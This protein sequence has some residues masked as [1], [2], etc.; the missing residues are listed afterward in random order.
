MHARRPGGVRRT[1]DAAG[2]AGVMEHIRELEPIELVVGRP[3]SLDGQERASAQTAQEFTRQLAAASGLPVRL[4]DERLSTAGAQRQLR[5]AGLDSRAQREI[6][7]AQAAVVILQQ[8]IDQEKS[9]GL[10]AGALLQEES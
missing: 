10:P 6:I 3:L 5:A 7:D 4:V 1:D 2:V 8:A 9:Q